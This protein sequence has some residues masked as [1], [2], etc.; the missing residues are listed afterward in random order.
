M[1]EIKNKNTTVYILY[2][3]GINVG[4]LLTGLNIIN[5][6]YRAEKIKKKKKKS[7]INTM[8]VI[9]CIVD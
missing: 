5:M 3:Q 1:M 4:I 8:A 6:F 2:Y 7:T 9:N